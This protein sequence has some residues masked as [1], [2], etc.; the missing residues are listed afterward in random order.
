MTYPRARTSTQA[1]YVASIGS[2]RSSGI[3]SSTNAYRASR[4]PLR[5][6]SRASRHGSPSLYAASQPTYP[7]G[8]FCVTHPL[9]TITKKNERRN[10]RGTVAGWDGG[11]PMRSNTTTRSRLTHH[12]MDFHKRNIVSAKGATHIENSR[13]MPNRN[14]LWD[15]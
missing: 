14:R 2:I 13:R 11:E 3:R 10:Q 8:E 1:R 7:N 4:F 6:S 12:N 9:H 15:K 5:C